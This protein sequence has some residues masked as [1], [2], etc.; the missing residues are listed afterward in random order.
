MDISFADN[1]VTQT[2]NYEEGCLNQAFIP[3]SYNYFT[4]DEMYQ[5]DQA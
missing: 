3:E 5:Q 4:T 2:P 1:A